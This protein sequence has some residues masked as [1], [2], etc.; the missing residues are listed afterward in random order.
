MNECMVGMHSTVEEWEWGGQ[1]HFPVLSIRPENPSGPVPVKL[2]AALLAPHFF[3]H[4]DPV[5]HYTMHPSPCPSPAHTTVR[6]TGILPALP[7]TVRTC[8]SRCFSF[9]VAPSKSCCDG[10]SG[11]GGSTPLHYVLGA[12]TKHDWF[13][14]PDF[15][16]KGK[17]TQ[18]M[19]WWYPN[20]QVKA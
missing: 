19:A 10:S 4:P 12:S 1:Q 15:R 3:S 7:S 11:L 8:L 18:I 13:R 20:H 9:S 2:Y 17:E 6:C 5:I 14:N 16:K